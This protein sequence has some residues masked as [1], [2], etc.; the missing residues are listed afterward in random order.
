VFAS[1]SICS[2]ICF[3]HK[4]DWSPWSSGLFLGCCLSLVCLSLHPTL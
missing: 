3:C 4:K 2:W 1:L